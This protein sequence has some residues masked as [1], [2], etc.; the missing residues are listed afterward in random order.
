MTSTVRGVTV[1]ITE[2]EA[3]NAHPSHLGRKPVL[4]AWPSEH[5][6]SHLSTCRPSWRCIR[7]PFRTQ[8]GQHR[9]SAPYLVP[10]M[11]T[12]SPVLTDV[13]R[14]PS[15]G[16]S[17]G[18]RSLGTRKLCLRSVSAVVSLGMS[19]FKMNGTG[20]SCVILKYHLTFR[21]I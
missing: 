16:A 12:A 4:K 2:H 20:R 13:V 3:P 7:T 11:R 9:P 14:R 10:S 15:H 17:T 21:G 8:W 1:F 6:R 18:A 19:A 5:R